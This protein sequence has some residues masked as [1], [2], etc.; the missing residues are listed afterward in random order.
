M[1]RSQRRSALVLLV[2]GAS[3]GVGR[4][5]GPATRPATAPAVLPA[6]PVHDY[7]GLFS[8]PVV[9]AADAAAGRFPSLF[10]KQ[11][12]VESLAAVPADR[13]AAAE[14]DPAAFFKAQMAARFKVL[15]LNGVYVM[16]C[17]D[18]KWVEVGVGRQTL[19]RGIFTTGDVSALTRALRMELKRG[20]YDAALA[21]AVDHVGRA[22]A[23][24]EG[25]PPPAATSRGAAPGPSTRP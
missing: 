4:A 3:C 7:A 12:V 16:I 10:G 24:H 25:R 15:N 2:V 17:L 18:P 1:R 21:M 13:L 8:A 19:G 14:A 20:R 9:A 5:A 11:M 6:G 22:Y 23:A